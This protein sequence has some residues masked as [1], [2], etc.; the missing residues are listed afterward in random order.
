MLT[1]LIHKKQGTAS[2]AVFLENN[3]EE[4]HFYCIGNY[5][6]AAMCVF[7]NLVLLLL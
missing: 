3:S 6:L 1:R 2:K 5:N 7:I 4:E